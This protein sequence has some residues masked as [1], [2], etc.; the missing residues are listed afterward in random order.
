MTQVDPD[1]G[2]PLW[3]RRRW[4]TLSEIVAI[5]ALALGALSFCDNRKQR[6]E[7]ELA[8]LT[9]AQR[10]ARR[11]ALVLR[12]DI[13]DN[14]A[15]EMLHPLGEDQVI[16]SQRYLFPRAVLAHAMEVDG[17][18]PQVDVAWINDGLRAQ[19]RAAAK[20]RGVKWDGYGRLPLGVLTT[21]VDN[22]EL[23]TDRSFYVIDYRV[24]PGGLLGGNP[25]IFFRGL[26]FVARGVG[27]DLQARLDAR[28]AT[29]RRWPQPQLPV[30][31]SVCASPRCSGSGKGSPA[32][33][34][35]SATELMQ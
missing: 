21:Y 19:I 24:T 22:G 25:R 20:A 30:A 27:A 23:R 34:K 32:T 31:A 16:Q 33:V 10:A 26:E 14:G 4:I 1:A 18:P 7:E 3:W 8:R 17:E 11:S 6:H 9:E 29:A 2:K 5:G 13:Y 15:R 12:A 28:W 35:E